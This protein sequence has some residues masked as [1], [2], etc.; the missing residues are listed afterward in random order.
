MTQY[1]TPTFAFTL[2]FDTSSV[3]KARISFGQDKRE[4]VKK[5][6][7]AITMQEKVISCELTQKESGMFDDRKPMQIQ[8]KVKTL[9]GNVL[10]TDIYEVDVGASLNKEIL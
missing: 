2:P 3:S 8:L 7:A 10:S 6:E 4:L 1:T 9:N 5:T